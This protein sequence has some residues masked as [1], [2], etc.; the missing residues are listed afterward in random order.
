LGIYE[1]LFFIDYRIN[2]DKPI[3]ILIIVPGTKVIEAGIGFTFFAGEFKFRIIGIDPG[4]LDFTIR[5]VGRGVDNGSGVVGNYSIGV[6]LV[7]H[8][9]IVLAGLHT[10][11]SYKYI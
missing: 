11:F 2:R 1:S 4:F 8:I 5:A 9:I 10:V 3:P 6:D 7:T